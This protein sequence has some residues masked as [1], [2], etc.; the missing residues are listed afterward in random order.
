MKENPMGTPTLSWLSA[1]QVA[2]AAPLFD[3]YRQF[4][5]LP[6][7]LSLSHNFL[8]ARLSQN[9]SKVA[10]AQNE[11]GQTIGFMQ[12]YP[13][14]SSLTRHIE[15]SKVW[16]LN[17]LYVT[18]EARGLNVGKALLDFAQQLAHDT[19]AAALMLETAKTNVI[20][21]SLYEKCGWQRDNEFYVYHLNC[22]K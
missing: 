5:K 12:L 18:P 16:L 7:D 10:I 14:F 11:L 2:L 17:D 21:Q 9:E 22:T 15:R 19:H 6:S 20:A 4:Y 8:H 1:D 3:D 13:L